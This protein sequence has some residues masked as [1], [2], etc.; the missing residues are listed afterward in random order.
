MNVN[1]MISELQRDEGNRLSVYDDATGKPIVRGYTLQ[2]HPTIGVGRALDVRG[3]SADEALVLLKNDINAF[4]LG[5]Q[6]AYRWFNSLD[7]VRQR[8]L[9]NM[10]FNLGL[11]GLAGFQQMLKA[12]EARD[13]QAAADAMKASRWFSQVGDRGERLHSAM[14]LGSPE[15]EA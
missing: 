11:G 9:V 8:A 2:G 13:W 6:Q 5:L 14:L 1:L 10:A 12:I 15:A 3:I 7:D 4:T